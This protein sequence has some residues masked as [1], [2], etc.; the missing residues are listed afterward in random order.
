VRVVYLICNAFQNERTFDGLYP[1]E[2]TNKALFP[3]SMCHCLSSMI[4]FFLILYIFFIQTVDKSIQTLPIFPIYFIQNNNFSKIYL[5]VNSYP[6]LIIVIS[7]NSEFN[8]VLLYNFKIIFYEK[9]FEN[10][11]VKHTT[12]LIS[13]QTQCNDST[14]VDKFFKSVFKSC[15]FDKYASKSYLKITTIN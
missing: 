1:A 2:K 11:Q 14:F 7:I 15:R 6:I 9:H 4:F 10:T 3:Y 5:E 12:K 8:V 13:F